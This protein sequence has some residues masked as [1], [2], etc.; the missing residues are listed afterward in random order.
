M[1]VLQDNLVKAKDAASKIDA[2]VYFYNG[3]IEHPRDL[4][5]IEAVHSHAGRKKAILFLVT[6]GGNPDA[7]YKI[8]RYFQE[9]YEHFTIV[10]SG[11]C[12]SAGT[13]IA[14]GAHE[15]AFSPYGELGPLDI[16]LTK[17]DK[18]D[19]LQSGLT[20]QDSLNTLEGRALEKFY[21]IVKDYMQANNG[22]LS[23]SSATKAASDFVTQLYAP[24]FSRIDPEE[25]GARARA[26]R[27]AA[28]YGR[29]LSVKSQNLKQD[30]LKLL[31]ETYS[32]HSFVID[33]QEAETLFVRV[34]STD[35]NE[36]AVIAALG[37]PA[38]FELPDFAFHALSKRPPDLNKAETDDPSLKGRSPSKDDGNTERAN[39]TAVPKTKKSERRGRTK[40]GR[41]V[42]EPTNG[43]ARSRV[44]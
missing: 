6:N 42:K 36:A 35:K 44:N 41:A 8:T 16:Q 25:I 5:T 37:R 7:A 34:R 12:K 10:V 22:L 15:L 30:T 1:P 31:A 38:R 39:G 4:T 43:G 20:I 9:K 2:D 40:N 21:E 28:D 26:M 19:Q 24:V 27:I 3:T 32:S 29:R 23:F 33:R 14:V 13:L 11:K 18:F 17:V